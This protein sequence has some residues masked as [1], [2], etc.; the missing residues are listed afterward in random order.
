VPGVGTFVRESRPARIDPKG[1]SILPPSGVIRLEPGERY[2]TLLY[3]YLTDKG[4]LTRAAAEKF[5]ADLGQYVSEYT[6]VSSGLEL[7]GVGRIYRNGNALAFEPMIEDPT[8]TSFGLKS[9]PMPAP[10]AIEEDAGGK[11]KKG[12]TSEKENLKSKA[13]AAKARGRAS[14]ETDA[15]VTKA[16]EREKVF[17]YVIFGF[18]AVF[19]V[20]ALIMLYLLQDKVYKERAIVNRPKSLVSST[21]R[22]DSIIKAEEK[23]AAESKTDEKPQP[24]KATDATTTP[25]KPADA[26]ATAGGIAQGKILDESQL[27]AGKTYHLIVD[28]FDSAADAEQSMKLWRE[29]GYTPKLIPG[30]RGSRFRLSVVQTRNKKELAKK[31]TAVTA[32]VPDAWVY[33]AN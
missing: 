25:E 11:K 23:L 15:E 16:K 27:A 19:I 12:K 26:P 18:L 20:F 29:R 17:N 4:G 9:L 30:G 33:S 7:R 3:Q 10:I 21:S 1:K 13:A 28:A 8:L 2:I 22:S 5:A 24:A 14:R 6:K 31:Y 32:L